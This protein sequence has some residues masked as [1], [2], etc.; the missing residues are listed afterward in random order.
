MTNKAEAKPSRSSKRSK[1]KAGAATGEPSTPANLTSTT[2]PESKT[3]TVIALLQGANGA[4]L[5]ELVVAT[6]WQPHTTRAALTGL[7]KKGHVISSQKTE[8][9]R[10]YRIGEA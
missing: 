6:S 9:V 1:S 4:S 8:G 10:R 2:K 7:K 3:Q 5:K